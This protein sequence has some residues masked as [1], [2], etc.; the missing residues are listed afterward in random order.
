[1]LCVLAFVFVFDAKEY[2][3]PCLHIVYVDGVACLH[4]HSVDGV[5]CLHTVYVDAVACLHIVQVFSILYYMIK[6]SVCGRSG[7]FAHSP[8]YS[9]S[10]KAVSAQ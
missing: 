8:G 4:T 6:N 9:L 3:R 10:C 7:L 1:M 5:A 2:G